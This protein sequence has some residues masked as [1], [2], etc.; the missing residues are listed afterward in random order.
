MAADLV[1][2]LD[3]GTTTVKAVVIS[4]D[5]QCLLKFGDS[6]PTARHGAGV[7]E[8][9]ASD[10]TTRIDRVVEHVVA[11]GLAPRIAAIGLTSQVN[12]H[13][14]L[15]AQGKSLMPAIVWQDG[16]AAAEA[17]E[18]D[19]GVTVA[20]KLAWWG[21]PMPIDASHA[22]SRMLW[23]A[24]HRSAI[25][26]KTASVVQPKDFCMGHLTGEFRTDPV[27]N[28][29][30]TDAGGGYIPGVLDLVPGAAQRMVPLSGV[31]EVMGHV[32]KGHPLAGVPV[33]TGTMDG[34]CALFGAGGGQDGSGVYVSGT[35][36]VLG[37]AAEAVHPT[38]G[39]IVFPK[40]GDVRLHAG[41]TQSGG[42]ALDWFCGLSGQTHEAVE[43]MVAA[44]PRAP[45]TPLFL[46]HLQGERAPL[47]NPALRGV[48]LGMDQ[49][50]G[51]PDLAR[52]VY[53]GVAFSARHVLDVLERSA[54]VTPETL[55]CGGGGFRSA[56]WTQIRANVLGRPLVLLEVNEPT[57]L[58]A[59]AL[60]AQGT[61]Q[62]ASLADAHRAMVRFGATVT[63]DLALRGLYDDLFGVYTRAIDA[64]AALNAKMLALAVPARGLSENCT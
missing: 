41:P 24:R 5:G 56:Q 11:A 37:I 19:A 26:A 28:I 12:T 9:D 10:W 4:L 30:L 15:D 47:W 27:S 16:R 22:L 64:N 20:Q 36:E 51:Q 44:S 14:F 63:P 62:F 29:G 59:T 60:A 46:P 42:A 1:L 53:E 48:F 35:S 2:G 58:G 7:V 23:V 45:L 49:A 34:W 38:P 21:A 52:A 57:L 50:T 40:L 25:W 18:L 3:V 43:A 39:V 33:V 17:A 55:A 54:G 31:T 6:Y 8:Q 61:G 13:L 32:R